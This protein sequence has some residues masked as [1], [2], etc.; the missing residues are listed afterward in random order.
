MTSGDGIQIGASGVRVH[1]ENITIQGDAGTFINGVHIIS[2]NVDLTADHVTVNSAPTGLQSRLHERY[3][4]RQQSP[5]RQF[6]RHW[7]FDERR[8]R[9]HPGFC[10]P[11]NR[12]FEHQYR[13]ILDRSIASGRTI[14]NQAP[15]ASA[16]SPIAAVD[17]PR[18]PNFRLCDRQQCDG[19]RFQ[20]AQARSFPSERTRSAGTGAM[21]RHLWAPH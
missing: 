7:I 11:R 20:L 1:L 3:V 10:D 15:T 8:F 4:F 16:W 14:R 9:N 18:F 17:L 5:R 13:S 21:A 19:S 6:H 2:P 12:C